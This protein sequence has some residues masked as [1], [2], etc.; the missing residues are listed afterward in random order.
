MP[1]DLFKISG[2]YV[3]DPLNGVDGQVRD[4]WIQGGKLI[5]PPADPN[6]RPTRT[7]NAA[8][9]VIMVLAWLVIIGGVK[10]IGRA[11]EKLSPLKVATQ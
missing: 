6:V 4:L 5:P 3:Y 9:L 11:A 7:L 10:S 1:D 8:G 2:G